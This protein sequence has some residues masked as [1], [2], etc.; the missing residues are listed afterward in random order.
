MNHITKSI[1]SSFKK[2]ADRFKLLSRRTDSA[3]IPDD[4][5]PRK[6][7]NLYARCLLASYF[8]K[9]SELSSS[10]LVS[11]ESNNY[12]IYALCA[13]SLIEITAALRYYV[14]EK[15][16]PLFDSGNF[17]HQKILDLIKLD[18][19]HLRGGRFDW[20]SFLSGN[21]FQE[22]YNNTSVRLRG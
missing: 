4:S 3:W 15:Y 11:I 2:D 6:L 18:D 19:Q 22:V 21:N 1:I 20:E 9:F 12:I 5:D 7:H 14:L 16:K 17:D 13:R 8:S 10:L